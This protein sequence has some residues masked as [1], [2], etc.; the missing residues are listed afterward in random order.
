MKRLFLFLSAVCLFLCSAKAAEDHW[1]YTPGSFDKEQYIYADFVLNGAT[2]NDANTLDGYQFAAFIGNQVRAIG[3][4]VANNNTP[5]VSYLIRFRVE[6]A[7]ADLDKAISFKVFNNTF[8]T[9]YD[10]STNEPLPTFTGDALGS[11]DPGIPSNPRHLY[12]SEATSVMLNVV[13]VDVNQTVNLLDFLTL[14]PANASI[15]NNIQWIYRE[16]DYYSISGNTLTAKSTPTT[17]GIPLSVEIGTMSAESFVFVY[18]PAQSL[19]LN[20]GGE[21]T[22]N[23]DDGDAMW[24]FLDNCYTLAPSTT[25]DRVVWTSG[26][27]DVVVLA[28]VGIGGSGRLEPW[29]VGDAVL[30]GKVYSFDGVEREAIAPITVT[31]HVKQPVTEI[32]SIYRLIECSV[33]DN[34][35]NYMVDGT[36]FNVLPGAATNKDVT[37]TLGANS[38]DGV[39]TISDTG[40]ITATGAGTA[41]LV[42]TSEDNS[43]VSLIIPVRVHNDYKTLTATEPVLNV[44]FT[45]QTV[46]IYDQVWNN[47]VPGPTTASDFYSAPTAASNAPSVVEVSIENVIIDVFYVFKAVGTGE[48]TITVSM[49]VCD[50]LQSTFDTEGNRHVS[51]VS[52]SFKV[53]VTQGLT[54]LTVAYVPADPSAGNYN[55]RLVVTPIPANAPMDVDN[56]NATA[57]Y[58]GS[59]MW[60]NNMENILQI[61]SFS[62]NGDGTAEASL[63]TNNIPGWVTFTVTYDDH[64]AD[65]INVMTDSQEMGYQFSVN[66]GW[67]WRT[68]P[69]CDL[70]NE[71][72]LNIFGSGLIEIRTQSQQVYNDPQYGLFGDLDLLDQNV[73]FKVKTGGAQTEVSYTNLYGGTLSNS[74]TVITLRRGWNWIPN[75]YVFKRY[76]YMRLSG[77][78]MEDDRIVSKN[79]GFT[80]YTDGRW[81]GTLE[82]LNP[83]QGYLFYNA[84]EAGRTLSMEGELDMTAQDDDYSNRSR[85]A[86]APLSSLYTYDAS[87]FRDNM[88]IVA[89]VDDDT[90]SDNLHAYAFVGDECRGEG[91]SVDGRLFITVHANSGEQ[92]SFKLYDELTDLLYD[93]EETVPMGTMLGTV[94]HPFQMTSI[95]VVTGIQTLRHAADA[96]TTYDLNG[97][98]VGTAQKGV[99]L[100]RQADG[101]VRKVVVK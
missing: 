44:L 73:C 37:I 81:T 100:Q 12:L 63:Y 48:A 101:T 50:Y 35:T 68:I 46:D 5:T 3:E 16:N 26:N 53:V 92:V 91:R 56:L 25:T 22:V 31:V 43:K 76:I 7:N 52:A 62:D 93:V 87:S 49:E 60:S 28:P 65:A 58:N 36:A 79:D 95:G 40:V 14:A 96:A 61:G 51:T 9:E 97:R 54:G 78:F 47:I 21:V 67:E 98:R 27:E 1:T 17:T 42:V 89:Q 10:L 71:N 74:S 41:Y 6:G 70:A 18:Q 13:K 88:T 8:N 23:V 57:I 24:T 55:D 38:A 86:R 83:G 64:V 99:S 69:Y 84:G 32:N 20:G 29:A 75:P 34:L 2:V 66:G 85:T 19:T 80:V 90:M 82:L 39:L 45:G 94:R 59:E 77:P 30:T 72:L 15:P 33:G 4:V 11:G